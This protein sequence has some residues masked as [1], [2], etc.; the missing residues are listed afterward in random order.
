MTSLNLG[1]APALP[2][3]LPSSPNKGHAGKQDKLII[4]LDFGTTYTGVSYVFTTDPTKIRVI[5][6]WE[7]EYK[8]GRNDTSKGYDIEGGEPGVIKGIKLGLDPSKR[9]F[10]KKARTTID[11]S[12]NA[13]VQP[14]ITVED[15]KARLRK[16]TIDIVA[17]YIGAVYEHAMSQ[18]LKDAMSS[19]VTSLKKEFTVTVP[20]IWSEEAKTATLQAA[21]KAHTDFQVLNPADL[22]TEP[23]AAALC[24]LQEFSNMG[25]LEG[26]T[27]VLCDAG[28]GTVDLIS[29]QISATRP[30]LEL[31]EIVPAS[32]G[33]VGSM[34]L[35]EAFNRYLKTTIGN[36][37]FKAFV[38]SEDDEYHDAVE[39]FE[40]DMKPRFAGPEE[41]GEKTAIRFGKIRFGGVKIKDDPAKNIANNSLVVTGKDLFDIF[42]PIVTDIE[43]LV[44][45][46][47]DEVKKKMQKQA[48]AIFLVGGFGDSPYL[49]K[50]L[51]KLVPSIEVTTPADAWSAVVRG[52]V[53]SKIPDAI[54]VVSSVASKSYGVQ[55]NSV[56]EEHKHNK[57]DA[58]HKFWDRWEGIYRIPQ[59]NWYIMKGEDLL[60]DRSQSISYFRPIPFDYKPAD[61]IFD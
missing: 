44:Q 34:M 56:F 43:A 13:I 38:E 58:E 30:K 41:W 15:E 59:M 33:L 28:G 48:R 52:A 35:D 19:Y 21:R 6:K 36:E 39:H 49:R 37:Q 12:V 27:F 54:R 51:E 53:L 17:D 22:I 16:S 50:Q 31:K 3:G 5:R 42:D 18:I 24:T 61:L 7:G 14:Q 45:K 46:Q 1:H 29:Y 25:L 32:G 10:W 9:E 2:L 26:D 11:A 57:E 47:L 55:A 4:G 8:S 40:K 20:A 60:R 23:E